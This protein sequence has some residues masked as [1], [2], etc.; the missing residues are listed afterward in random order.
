M[1]QS[2]DAYFSTAARL[3]MTAEVQDR[4]GRVI[5]LDRFFRILI[6]EVHAV[7]ECGNTLAFVGNGGS[8]AIASHMAIDFSKN[9]G[10][11]ARAFNDGAALTCLGNDLGY[12]NVFAGQIEMH[13]RPGDLLFA[14]SSSGRSQNILNAVAA[15]RAG[16]CGVVTLSGF[17]PDNPLRRLGDYN[18]YVA[19]HEY[20]LVEI[21]HLSLCHALL[22][23]ALGWSQEQESASGALAREV[24]A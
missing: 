1:K 16:G 2:L 7:H 10:L 12:E 4:E 13:A 14:I 17:A 3:P 21:A 24:A 22:D 6:G 8:A 5:A 15:G 23:M 11:R 18:V 9:G 20:G 19:S